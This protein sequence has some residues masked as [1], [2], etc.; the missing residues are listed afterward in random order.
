[1]KE[2]HR[3]Q[4]RPPPSHFSTACGQ[5]LAHVALENFRNNVNGGG[6]YETVKISK[7]SNH[8]PKVGWHDL[9]RRAASNAAAPWLAGNR[10]SDT[11]PHGGDP[12]GKRI[13]CALDD[14]PLQFSRDYL[15]DDPNPG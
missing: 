6:T 10:R 15:R 12:F 7:P 11:L 13:H 9:C 14:S 1:M 4:R 5:R 8:H 3:T 2:S